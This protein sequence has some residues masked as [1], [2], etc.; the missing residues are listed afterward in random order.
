VAL[1]FICKPFE[2]VAV[3]VFIDC[4]STWVKTAKV[5]VILATAKFSADFR[6]SST[7]CATLPMNEVGG[8]EVEVDVALSASKRADVAEA[9]TFK[10]VEDA[11]NW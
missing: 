6:I 9:K 8:V 5:D 3:S 4:V 1:S 7:A 11:V 2:T 10:N